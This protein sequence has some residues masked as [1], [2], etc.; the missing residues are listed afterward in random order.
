VTLLGLQQY[1]DFHLALEEQVRVLKAL[2]SDVPFFLVGGRAL[3]TGRGDE[4]TPLVDETDYCL[5]LVDPRVAIPTALAYSWLTP[6]GKS[7]SIEGFRAEFGSGRGEV[8]AANDFEPVVFARYPQLGII[9]DEL[10]CAGAVHASLSGSGSVVFGRFRSEREA[11]RAAS[12]M[13]GCYSVK[14]SRPLSRTDYFS[15]MTR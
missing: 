8:D 4:V 5:L 7:N 9:R 2:G 13:S 15:R 3:G 10:V 11:E 14:V 12:R 1:C 6:I